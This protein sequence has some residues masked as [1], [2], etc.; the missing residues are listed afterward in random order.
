[1]QAAGLSDEERKKKAAKDAAESEAKLRAKNVRSSSATI[2]AQGTV[3]L[4]D[5]L[6]RIQYLFWAR[7]RVQ[8]LL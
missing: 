8:C 7:Q 2:G 4:F 3:P 1:M 6:F 5:Q